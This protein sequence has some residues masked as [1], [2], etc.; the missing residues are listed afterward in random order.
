[1]YSSYKLGVGVSQRL[2]LTPFRDQT[3]QRTRLHSHPVLVVAAIRALRSACCTFT[4]SGVGGGAFADLDPAVPAVAFTKTC[5]QQ[6]PAGQ[7]ERSLLEPST[8]ARD[9][10]Q[11]SPDVD[12]LLIDYDT[13]DDKPCSSRSILIAQ[14]TQA[15][16]RRKVSF[17]HDDDHEQSDDEKKTQIA[18]A[19]LEET[20]NRTICIIKIIYACM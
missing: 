16:K 13:Q 9:V 20:I 10:K 18:Q 7:A 15:C 14:P 12:V 19:E 4:T 2:I 8:S 5:A 3:K 17:N 6:V 1:M 11:P